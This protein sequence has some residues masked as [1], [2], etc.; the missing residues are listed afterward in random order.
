MNG[1]SSGGSEIAVIHLVWAP[2]G[3]T[4]L[5]EFLEAYRERA[6]GVEHRLAVILNGFD[7]SNDPRRAE[8]EHLLAGVDHELVVMHD[9]VSDLTAYRDAAARVDAQT[10]CFL[11][12][13]SRPL[14]DGWLARLTEPLSDPRVGLTGAGGSHESLYSAAPFWL[15]R[16]R[17]PD[18]PPFPNPHVR[19]NGF[20]LSRE[21]ALSLDWPPTGR[22]LDA[23]RLESGSHSITRQVL[24]R[25]LRVLVVGC[26][27][28]CYP[29]ERWAESA[30]Y[31]CGDQSNLLISDNRT[32][33]YERARTRRRRQL[34]A[35]TWGEQG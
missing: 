30:T 25:G 2:L 10:L 35:I 32:R 33:E 11:N 23:W 3:A 22:K 8:I 17:K 13:Y 15:R 9:P 27:G 5:G 19:T 4:M 20:A 1:V 24:E 34:A 28:T 31:R 7:G 29:P 14:A 18:F 16:R 6:A 12:S 26:D 21:L